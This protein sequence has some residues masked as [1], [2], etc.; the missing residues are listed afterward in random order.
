MALYLPQPL[1]GERRHAASK[2]RD[3]Y[4]GQILRANF[5]SAA[6][7]GFQAEFCDFDIRADAFANA[8]SYGLRAA[9]GTECGLM[10]FH[11]YML[12]LELF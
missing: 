9:R 4:D 11:F 1:Y 7:L 8:G 6:F 12:L 5:R 3:S 2:N 10:D